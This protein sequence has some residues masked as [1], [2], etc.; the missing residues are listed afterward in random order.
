MAREFTAGTLSA[1][2]DANSGFKGDVNGAGLFIGSSV[3]PLG[4]PIHFVTGGEFLTLFFVDRASG[5]SVDTDL[6]IGHPT[7]HA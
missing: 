1:V 3:T 7:T 5:A 2:P 6:T 4:N